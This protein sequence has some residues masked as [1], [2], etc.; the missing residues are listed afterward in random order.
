MSASIIDIRIIWKNH[1]GA[2]NEHLIVFISSEHLIDQLL[3]LFRSIIKNIP[4]PN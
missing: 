3:I 4:G 1:L 2:N